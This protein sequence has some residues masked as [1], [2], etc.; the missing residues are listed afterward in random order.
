[1]DGI[2]RARFAYPNINFRY[3]ISP[4]QE[5]PSADMRLPLVSLLLNFLDDE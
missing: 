3:I 2:L 1:M 5:L 4:S